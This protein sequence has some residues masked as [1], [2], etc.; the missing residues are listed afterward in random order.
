MHSWCPIKYAHSWQHIFGALIYIYAVFWDPEMEV[1]IKWKSLLL[2][3]ASPHRLTTA[4][5]DAV[6]RGFCQ[7]GLV[8]F[9]CKSPFPRLRVFLL[10]LCRLCEFLVTGESRVLIKLA[11]TSPLPFCLNHHFLPLTCFKE[12]YLFYM[13]IICLIQGLM[14]CL[15]ITII[16]LWSH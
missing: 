7:A 1:A 3:L 13:V 16:T 15:G 10:S 8:P 14:K 9:L 5:T 2:F 4:G 6:H 11:S 12:K